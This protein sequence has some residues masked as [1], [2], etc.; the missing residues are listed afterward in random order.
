MRSSTGS[1]TKSFC[2]GVAVY[3]QLHRTLDIGEQ[4]RDLLALTFEGG[5]RNQDLFGKML[6]CVALG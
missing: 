5:P 3:K 1:R 2:A 6:R 4:H